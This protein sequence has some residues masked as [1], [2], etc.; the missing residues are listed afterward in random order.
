MGHMKR[1]KYVSIFYNELLIHESCNITKKTLIYSCYEVI[2]DESTVGDQYELDYSSFRMSISMW[3]KSL[4]PLHLI[5]RV[6]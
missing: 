5:L 1:M 3:F 2:N 6:F 4:E